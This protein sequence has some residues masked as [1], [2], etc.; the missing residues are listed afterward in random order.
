[1][2]L[3]Y[4]PTSTSLREAA[5]WVVYKVEGFAPTPEVVSLGRSQANAIVVPDPSVSGT[6]ATLEVQPGQNSVMVTDLGSR[7]GTFIQGARLAPQVP[8]EAKSG[9][10]ISFGRVPLRYIS[11][12]GLLAY[13]AALRAQGKL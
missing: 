12:E 6:H 3:A 13:M 4:M 10:F 7:N 9:D 5:A 11:V 8:T 1:M 2:N